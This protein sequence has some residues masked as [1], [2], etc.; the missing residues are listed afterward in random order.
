MEIPSLLQLLS[1]PKSI[2]NDNRKI[3]YHSTHV[4]GKPLITL[5]EHYLNEKIHGTT[6]RRK[7]CYDS[8][9]NIDF[10]VTVE[11]YNDGILHGQWKYQKETYDGKS[12][13]TKLKEIRNFRR[14]KL[15]GESITYGECMIVEQWSNENL[16]TRKT[17]D[18]LTGSI[19][20]ITI[21]YQLSENKETKIV[22]NCKIYDRIPD[23]VMTDKINYN[24][25]LDTKYL[26]KDSTGVANR[27]FM[28]KNY[29][30]Q[31][32]DWLQCNMYFKE[33]KHI[34]IKRG[35]TMLCTEYDLNDNV[36]R[37]GIVDNDNNILFNGPFCNSRTYDDRDKMLT[38]GNQ[39]KE[40]YNPNITPRN[41]YITTGCYLEGQ[42]DGLC[43]QYK[44]LFKQSDEM[45]LTSKPIYEV[46][47][48]K[49]IIECVETERNK[50]GTVICR[51]Y[52]F[53]GKEVTREEYIEYINQIDL[54]L[55]NVGIIK[56]LTTTLLGYC[57]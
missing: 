10:M 53:A 33:V 7:R 46:S 48:N 30:L 42:Y 22:V 2:I 21:D 41:K 40:L 39:E 20:V 44:G 5:E 13:I 38:I 45:I 17:F 55:Q 19:T 23:T 35:N 24:G 57:H 1:A 34:L 28:A 12:C 6:I 18:P 49:G 27:F 11:N 29:S 32:V 56:D 8:T 50:H 9:N 4:N 43:R 26:K 54:L 52:H 37:N 25:W 16:I 3:V 31:F 36:L 47:Y 51:R 14:G 15:H